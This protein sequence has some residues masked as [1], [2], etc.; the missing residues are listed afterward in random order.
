MSFVQQ[1][2]TITG[3]AP[4]SRRKALVGLS[5]L[6]LTACSRSTQQAQSAGSNVA[7]YTC[8]MHPFV[9]SQDPKGKC[10]I[11]G[12]DLVPVLKPASTGGDTNAA[13][14]MATSTLDAN[15]TVNITPERMQEI[16]VTTELVTKRNLT[17]PLRAP[18]RAEIDES[19]LRDINV[20][21]GAGYITKLYASYEGMSFRK[22][23]PLMTV[24]CEGWLQ[25]QIDYIKAYRAWKRTP[26]V[27]PNNSIALDN[28]LELMRARIRVWDLS[29]DQ[30][31]GLEK[32]A[33]STNEI[34]LKTGHGL[35]GSFDLL[36]PFNGY[37]HMKKA[38][39]GMHFDAGQSLLELADHSRVWIV[40]QFSEDQAM[41][42]NVGQKVTVTFPS[43]PQ[44]KLPGE[45]SFIDPHVDE[46]QRRIMARIV[47]SDEGHMFHPGLF[48]EVSGEV[49]MG[50]SLTISTGAVVPTG[51]KFIVF[52]D[53]GGGKLEPREVE[54]GIHTGDYY[55][56][57]SG[58]NEGDRIV[59]SANFL[60]DAESRIQG[61][62]KTWGD[63]P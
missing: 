12:M 60:V 42:V 45:I 59:S 31:A 33:L 54:M 7:Y 25:T 18:A 14:V 46:Q 37:V 23:Q 19:S 48:A 43:M 13:P 40:A 28:Q 9:R 57:V 36:A 11:C 1:L 4:L 49:P 20:K 39:E 41:Y 30:I 17:R 8:T 15:G 16:G 21:A 6:A 55:E 35:S 34:D 29:D 62:L 27:S 58:L 32:F 3:N 26:L 63:Q 61:V 53:H 51:S 56:V 52:V 47:I 22:G 44:H 5:L 24:L 38:V 10:P 50:D 2:Q